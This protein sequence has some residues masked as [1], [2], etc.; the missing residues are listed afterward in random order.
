MVDVNTNL[1][2]GSKYSQRSLYN[3][4]GLVERLLKYHR[5]IIAVDVP[6][7]DSVELIDKLGI[8]YIS[9]DVVSMKSENVLPIPTKSAIRIKNIKK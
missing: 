2:I 7:W 5:P 4:R 6:S 8:N 3:F 1:K 9:S